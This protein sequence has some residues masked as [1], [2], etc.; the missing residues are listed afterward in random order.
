MRK[1][2]LVLCMLYLVSAHAQ[3]VKPPV[4]GTTI[5]ESPYRLFVDAAFI[6]EFKS[7]EKV[8]L[9]GVEEEYFKSKDSLGRKILILKSDFIR[10]DSLMKFFEEELALIDKIKKEK[11]KKNH[12]AI[13]DYINKYGS[14]TDVYCFMVKD[15]K[16]GMSQFVFKLIKTENPISINYTETE[17]GRDEQ[18]VYPNNVYYYFKKGKLTAIQ[19]SE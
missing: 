14:K 7:G 2:F 13:M 5:R 3:T 12:D 4:I 18:W 17:Y 10:P 11:E 9:T 19:A 1:T 15:I 8:L 6:N 16:I